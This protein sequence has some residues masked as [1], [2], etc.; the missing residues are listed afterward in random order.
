[1]KIIR[2]GI[3]MLTLSVGS[4][5]YAADE[6]GMIPLSLEVSPDLNIGNNISFIFSGILQQKAIKVRSFVDQPPINYQTAESPEV[7]IEPVAEDTVKQQLQGLSKQEKL[8]GVIFGHIMQD[9][10]EEAVY[11]IVRVYLLNSEQYET[12]GNEEGIK[13]QDVKPEVIK[14]RLEQIGGQIKQSLGKRESQHPSIQPSSPS[15]QPDL[16]TT[17]TQQPCQKKQKRV[18]DITVLL[19]ASDLETSS[20]PDNAN[21]T[22]NPKVFDIVGSLGGEEIQNQQQTQVQNAGRQSPNKIT[23]PPQL[24]GA[25]SLKEIYS[26][27]YEER[28]YAVSRQGDEKVLQQVANEKGLS[29]WQRINDAWQNNREKRL[30]AR[31]FLGCWMHEIYSK[32]PYNQGSV[33]HLWYAPGYLYHKRAWRCP[34]RSKKPQNNGKWIKD[35]HENIKRELEDLNQRGRFDNW[36]IPQLDELFVMSHLLPKPAVGQEPYLFW[37]STKKTGQAD[38]V[39]GLAIDSIRGS[40]IYRPYVMSLNKTKARAFLIPV[41]DHQQ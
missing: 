19:G 33:Y 3:I 2:T 23:S 14:E 38:M 11:V 29:S 32:H 39:W 8:D 22:C 27:L 24:Q 40:R 41:M 25:K 31:R 36:R 13:V 30:V 20:K 12:F 21:S 26:M 10:V 4:L 1:M 17:R 35:T 7:T 28:F 9:L 34:P 5:V 37:S 18:D 15:K 6:Y 16:V